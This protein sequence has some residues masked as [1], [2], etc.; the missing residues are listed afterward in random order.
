MN[1][2]KFV[3]A[4]I[5]FGTFLSFYYGQNSDKLIIVIDPGHGGIDSGAVGVNGVLEKDIVLSI[6]KRIDS[7]N[8]NLFDDRFEIY[9]TRYHD[10][11]IT[12]GDRTELAIRLN[13]AIFISLHCNQASNK[14]ANGIEVYVDERHKRY[15]KSSF[16]LANI[17]QRELNDNLGFKSRGVKT[18]NF[19]VLRENTDNCPAVLLEL[20]YLSSVDEAEHLINEEKH[21]GIALVILESIIKNR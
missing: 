9:L 19:Q 12:L 2:L 3:I 14:N 8:A 13:A 21:I 15:S 10:T 20:G 7:L 4:G 18:A 17:M 16:R 1:F 5:I 6:A 11:L